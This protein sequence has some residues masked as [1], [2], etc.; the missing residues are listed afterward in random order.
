MNEYQ[1]RNENRYSDDAERV[2]QL[3][4]ELNKL[5]AETWSVIPRNP[6]LDH[7]P[8]GHKI[9]ASSGLIIWC[10]HN[11]YGLDNRWRFSACGWPSYVDTENRR[12]SVDTRNLYNPKEAHPETT[13]ADTRPYPN[14]AKQIIGKLITPYR[15]IYARCAQ[16]AAGNDAYV[17]KENKALKAVIEATGGVYVDGEKR[18]RYLTAFVDGENVRGEFHSSGRVVLTLTAEQA[19]NA[20]AVLTRLG[21]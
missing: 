17:I 8:N 18:Q 10:N 6:D 20:L 9:G 16:S 14:I 5:D 11:G 15:A 19:V 4:E 7:A 1:Q 12:V 2:V 13:A 3:V 21:R